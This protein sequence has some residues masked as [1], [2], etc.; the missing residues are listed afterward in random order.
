MLNQC[1]SVATNQEAAASLSMASL[2]ET[3]AG[4]RREHAAAIQTHFL[5]MVLK[6]MVRKLHL[7]RELWPDVWLDVAEAAGLA[8]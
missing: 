7:Q 2:E 1:C 4:I 6:A 8:D 5:P 3:Q